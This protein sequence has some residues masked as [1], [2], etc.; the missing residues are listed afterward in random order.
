MNTTIYPPRNGIKC[1]LFLGRRALKPIMLFTI[2]L[3]AMKKIFL[4]LPICFLFFA[5]G[6]KDDENENPLIGNKWK[7]VGFVDDQTGIIREPQ[8]NNCKECYLLFFNTNDAFSG[9]SSTNTLY[10]TYSANSSSHTIQFTEIGG[11][12]INELYDGREFVNSLSNVVSFTLSI[13]ELKLFYNDN[14]YLL[15]N[16]YLP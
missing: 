14:L 10:G 11:T 16:P 13:E 2:N 3:K 5:N 9:H 7:L 6:C 1:Y 15:F 8:P 4:I 12:K